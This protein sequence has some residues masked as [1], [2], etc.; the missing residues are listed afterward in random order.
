MYKIAFFLCLIISII[1][2]YFLGM[3]HE[4]INE[5]QRCFDE[6]ENQNCFE[7]NY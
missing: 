7:R 6:T 1:T 5:Q 2:A 3:T 4:R